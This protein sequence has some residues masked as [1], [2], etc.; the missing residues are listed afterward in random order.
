[1]DFLIGLEQSALGVWVRESAS[2]WAYPT[3]LF[4]H[5]AGLAMLVGVSTAVDLRILGF[6]PSLPLAP[7]RRFF[8]LMW[9]GFWINTV[10]GL[11]LLIADASTKVV[12][13]VFLI[14]LGLVGLAV[15][16]IYAI[17]RQVFR[18]PLAQK[19]VMPPNVRTLAWAS[20]IL[21]VGA[22]TTG[23]LMAYIGPVSG[24]E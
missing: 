1:M 19:T 2:L 12:N 3:I 17:D 11:A 15:A 14:K 5:T 8:P 7:M 23:R 4:L 20:L 16:N 13:P 18:G 22:I 24:L 10:S 6:A 9:V 21:W